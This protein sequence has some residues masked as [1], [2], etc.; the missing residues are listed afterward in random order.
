MTVTRSARRPIPRTSPRLLAALTALLVATATVLG[1]APL[2]H[3]VGPDQ[4]V[5]TG[6]FQEELGC[7]EDWD[8]ACAATALAPTATAGVWES[9]FELPA[10]QW[11][12]RTAIGGSWD[13]AYGLDGGE[14]NIPLAVAAPARVTFRFDQATSRLSVV[15]TDQGGDYSADDGTLASV[16]Y[17]HPGGGEIFYF[18]LT[19]RFENGDASNDTGGIEG[20][21]IDHGFDP[22]DKGFYQ[23]GDIAGL[24]ERLDYVEDLG[25]TSIWLTPSFTNNPVQGEGEDASAGYHGYWVTDFTTI[26]PHLGTN[27]ELK[28]LIEDAHSRGITVYFDIITNHT[29]DLIDYEE[30]E[31]DYV[32]QASAPY[33]DADGDP[34]D[35]T[36][37]AQSEQFPTFDPETSFPYTPVR[38][39]DRPQMVPDV[40]NDVTMYHNRGNSTWEGESVTFG[41]FDGLDDLMTEDPRVLAAMEEVYTAW[42]DFGIDGFRIDTAKHVDLAFWQSFTATLVGHQAATPAGEGFFTF[43][44]VYDADARLLAPY[45]RDTDM[46]SVLDFAF[47]SAATD[48]AR[49]RTAQGMAGLFATDDHYTTSHSSSADLPTFV[50][51]H[52]M[53]RIGHLLE[54][55]DRL[56]ER[57]GLA[58]ETMLL[59]RGQ[60]VIYYGDEQGFVGDGADKDARQSMFPSQVPSYLDD[61][62]ID[63]TPYGD[64]EHFS[65][66]AP[67]YLLISELARLRSSTPALATGAQIERYAE[68]GAG[69]YAFSRVDREERIEHLVALNNASEERTVTLTA[70]TPGATFT[71]LYGDHAPLTAAADGTLEVTVPS[72][73]AL[74]LRADAPVAPAGDAQTIGLSSADGEKVEG[75]A[76]IIADVA[77]DRW[78]E[79]SFAYRLAGEVAWTALGTAEDDSPRVFHDVA[80]LPA[81]T[82][83]EYRAVSTDTA[84]ERVAAS[85][86]AVVGADLSAEGPGEG[87][88][89]IDEQS[90]TV[91]GSHNAAMGCPGDWQPDC[92]EA[93]LVEDPE[94][95]LFTGT[96]DVPAGDH[97]YKVAIGGSWEEN[98]GVGGVPGGDDIAYTHEGGPLTFWYDPSTHVVSNSAEG[99]FVTLPGSFNAAL[100]CS[101]D[102]MPPCMRTWM[103]DPDGDGVLTFSTDSLPGGSYEVKPAH[104]GSWDENYGVG[105]ERGGENYTFSTQEGEI[106]NFSYD[107][108]THVLTIEAS[109]PL[110]AGSGKQLGHLVDAGTVAWPAELVEDASQSRWELFTAPGGGLG[111]EDGE[112]TGGESLGELALR[113]GGLE[114][115]E[116]DGRRHLADFLALDLPELDRTALEE[117]LRGEL[118][119]A[120][121]GP[122]GL[123]VFTG[124]QIPGVLDD[125]YAEDAA[126]QQLGVSWQDGTPTLSL[127]APTARSVTVQL[128]GPAKEVGTGA[129]GDPISAGAAPAAVAEVAM[130]RGPGGVWTA[131]GEE[132]WADQAYTYA[133]DVF[134]PSA[135]EVLTNT[136]TDPYSVGLTLNSQHSVMLDL[137][138]PRWAPEVWTDTAAPVVDQFAEQTIYELHLRD[139]SAGDEALP[140]EVRGSYAA[141]GHPDS[142]GTDRLA[143]LAGAGMTTVHLL[144]TFDIATIEEDRAAQQHPQIPEDAGPASTEQQEAVTA[145]ADQDAYNWGYDPMHYLSPEGSYATDGHQVGGDRTAEFRSMVGELHAMGLQVVLDQVYNHTAAHGQASTSVL[146][147]IVPGYYHRLSLEGAVETSTCCSNIATEHAMGERIMVDSTVLWAREYGVDGFRFDLMGHH[148]AENMLAVREALDALTLEDDGVDGKRI[149]LYGE[150]WDFGE[151]AGNARFTQA[152]QGQLGGT[153]IGTFNDRLRDA[154]HGGSPFD[155]DKRT[156]QGFG[157]GLATMPNGFAEVGEEEQ[158]TDLRHRTDLIRIGMAGNLSDYELLGSSGEVVRGDEL[159]YNGVPAGYATRPEETVNYVDAHDNEALYDMNVW[160]LPQDAPMDVRVRMNTLSLATVTLGQSPSFWAGGTDLMRSKSLDRDSYNSGDHFNV[161][162]WTQQSSGFGGGLPPA[163]KNAEAWELMTPMLEDPEKTPTSEDIG[164]SSEVT[165]DLLRLRSSTPLITL[166]DAE[167]IRQ[168]V[169]FPNAGPEATAG[170]LVMRIDDTVGPDADPALDG[171]VTVFNASPEPITEQVEGMAG[172]GY[173]LHEVQVNGADEVV[174]GATWEAETGTVTVPAHTVAVFVAPQV[175]GGGEPGVEEPGGEEPGGEEPGGDDGPGDGEG[176]GDGHGGEEPGIG[177][178]QPGEGTGSDS[179]SG[180]ATSSAPSD[181][182]APAVPSPAADGAAGPLARTGVDLLPWAVAVAVALGLG[183]A[184]TARARRQG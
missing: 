86:T 78:A 87:A 106:V 82:L 160:K 76:P 46:D 50:G 98:Y 90:V 60:P 70:L 45:V 75:L 145:I 30:G 56:P 116:L 5:L 176:A 31:Y 38:D 94:S 85:A 131:A 128:H 184:L 57:A 54:G 121:R 72:L 152:T 130:E 71:P 168:K 21:R 139:F 120:Q 59:S 159:D 25:M 20:D 52:D 144:P 108:A 172:V 158:L 15:L 180:P 80:G 126:E 24:H 51:N 6:S 178:Q 113:E 43:G 161:I 62:L 8:P 118:A 44:E 147:R 137:A 68:E 26:D 183:I 127:W 112:V 162:D 83:I 173:E 96:F 66:D 150:G 88:G 29:A 89:G 171:L 74:V 14:E 84:G 36:K 39:E 22:T 9:T 95:G 166:G 123:E 124:L 119:L 151:I 63:G 34:V 49:G 179:D 109:D 174:K 40:L 134:V 1:T 164:L 105:G 69:V 79:T 92:A 97:S 41:D 48:W 55:S 177:G 115:G 170:L 156:A 64:G 3:A 61:A 17:R 102:W 35:V 67:L 65:T 175:G 93:Q 10:G 42:M 114:E 155:T 12:A 4:P 141:V 138:D 7:A 81:G 153:S 23:G 100:G 91:P 111:I 167:L 107:L 122:D 73:G 143:E 32:D 11:E 13:E 182:P 149:Y 99:P 169:S 148:S 28:A 37:L 27:E 129:G 146:D 110:T 165:L 142:R 136:V 2:V 16:P 133:V 117:A 103:Q 53:G 135:G 101:E 163:E 104:G 47:Q 154:V 125:L 132:D 19:D 77:A 58:H 181:G 33:L 140:E 157:N 18:V